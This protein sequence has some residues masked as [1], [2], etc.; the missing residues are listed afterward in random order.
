[1]IFGVVVTDPKENLLIEAFKE[2]IAILY[3]IA[4]MCFLLKI[5]FYT[6]YF[7]LI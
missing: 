1:M 2:N 6:K 3:A 7:D 5:L 4:I